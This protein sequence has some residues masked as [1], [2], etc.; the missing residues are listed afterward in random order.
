MK[1]FPVKSGIK[2]VETLTKKGFL[3][4]HWSFFFFYNFSFSFHLSC[5]ICKLLGM[6]NKCFPGNAMCPAGFWVVYKLK[7][8]RYTL[9]L[10]YSGANMD[11]CSLLKIQ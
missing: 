7:F 10:A 9:S 8:A 4:H 5:R 3:L 1:L 6:M 11:K 2:F